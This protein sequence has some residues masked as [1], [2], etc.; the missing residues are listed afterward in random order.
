MHYQI[1][2]MYCKWCSTLALFALLYQREQH[3]NDNNNNN[4]KLIH[5]YSTCTLEGTGFRFLLKHSL[6]DVSVQKPT[7]KSWFDHQA[8][9]IDTSPSQLAA[10]DSDWRSDGWLRWKLQHQT[11]HLW[12]GESDYRPPAPHDPSSLHLLP[13]VCRYPLQFLT[14]CCWR[15]DIDHYHNL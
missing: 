5:S 1:T 2:L 14:P 8:W 9:A 3:I 6:F 13:K 7:H 12:R 4:Q 10:S 15:G 11:R